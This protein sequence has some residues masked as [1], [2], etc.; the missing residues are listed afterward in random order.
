M[1]S[2]LGHKKCSSDVP[3]GDQATQCQHSQNISAKDTTQPQ[4]KRVVYAYYLGSQSSD[5]HRSYRTQARSESETAHLQVPSLIFGVR[6]FISSVSHSFRT[7]AERTEPTGKCV[8]DRFQTLT[9]L[10]ATG[11][12]RIM[13]I[14]GL[15]CREDRGTMHK[16]IQFALGL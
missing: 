13:V 14:S 2:Q 1:V 3:F 7:R 11:A 12:F 8:G 4:E 6:D 16:R 10:P 5:I 15:L 9:G